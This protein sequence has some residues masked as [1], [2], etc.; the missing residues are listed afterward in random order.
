[1]AYGIYFERYE[2]MSWNKYQKFIT[3]LTLQQDCHLK[4]SVCTRKIIY[5]KPQQ[6]KGESCLE[7]EIIMRNGDTRHMHLI[8]KRKQD[9]NICKKSV[10]LLKED[11]EKIL[12]G[13]IEWIKKEKNIDLYDFYYYL[14]EEGYKPQMMTESISQVFDF[15]YSHNCILV[16]TSKRLLQAEPEEFFM[17]KL[18]GTELIKP[19]KVHIIYR[20]ENTFPEGAMQAMNLV[21]NPEFRY[22]S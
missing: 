18:Q 10:W 16:Q 4:E 1:M 17:K 3:K 7:Y 15:P 8:G 20:T 14:K 9:G 2:D 13:D 11:C 19:G 6:G 5:R 22:V 12:E 21:N